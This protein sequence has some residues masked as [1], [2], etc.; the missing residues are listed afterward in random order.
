MR[1]ALLI[2]DLVLRPLG[3]TLALARDYLETPTDGWIERKPIGKP[4]LALAR[5]TTP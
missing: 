1:M 3:L 4:H 2:A 5:R